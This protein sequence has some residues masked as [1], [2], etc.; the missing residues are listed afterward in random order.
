MYFSIKFIFYLNREVNLYSNLTLCIQEKEKYKS[1][2]FY[3][4]IS[5]IFMHPT[6]S[7]FT[8]KM[9]DEDTF[10][11]SYVILNGIKKERVVHFLFNLYYYIV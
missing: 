2:Q 8:L 3:D 11:M 10:N 5:S 1:K 7:E 4:T 6:I 9:I